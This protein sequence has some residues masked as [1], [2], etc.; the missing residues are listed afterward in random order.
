MTSHEY[1]RLERAIRD[2]TESQIQAS[3]HRLPVE[4][5]QLIR[6][7]IVG[8]RTNGAFDSLFFVSCP[9]RMHYR[10]LEF[11]RNPHK[12][13]QR[14]RRHLLFDVPAMNLKRN[15]TDPKLGRRLLVEKAADDER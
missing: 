1:D 9:A 6:A 8:N 2:E 11:L 14:G 10:N 5:L 12:I 15:L 4:S 7:V 3:P 13:G